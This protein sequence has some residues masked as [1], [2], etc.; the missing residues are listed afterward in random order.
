V[1]NPSSTTSQTALSGVSARSGTDAWAVGTA[2]NGSNIDST[3]TMHWNG[4]TWS[5]KTSPNPG[6]NYNRL[7]GVDIV[8]GGNAWAT[9]WYDRQG[10]YRS[11]V[12]H[13][14]GTAWSK[15][16]SPNPSTG[17]VHQLVGVSAASSTDVWAVGYQFL[18]PV[19]YDSF[20]V[21]W[22]GVSWKTKASPS[23]S[24]SYNLL[25][26]VSALSSTDAWAVGFDTDDG[27][28]HSVT[29]VEHWDGTSWSVS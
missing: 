23:P 16:N 21:H 22:N 17:T 26:G 24:S 28:G 10:V 25:N 4:T 29:L 7:F 27:T 13:W 5:K 11:L 6:T 14:N 9:G 19:T 20:I 2:T 15:V 8:S 18:P 12:L 1:R 3:V